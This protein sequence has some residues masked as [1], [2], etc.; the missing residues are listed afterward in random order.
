MD[1]AY[2]S[3]RRNVF[4]YDGAPLL[5]VILPSTKSKIRLFFM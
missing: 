3:V 5:A 1:D 4:R 2:Q